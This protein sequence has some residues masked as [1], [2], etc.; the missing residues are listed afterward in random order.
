MLRKRRGPGILESWRDNRFLFWLW[1]LPGTFWI[2]VFFIVPLSLLWVYSFGEKSGI[3]DIVISWT[4]A[5]YTRV[6][7]PVYLTIMWKSFWISVVSTFICL[8]LAYPIA[9]AICFAPDKWKPVLLLIT[10]LPFWINLLIRTY[11]LLAV[12]RTNGFVNQA[13]GGVWNGV[14]Y[15]AT[16]GSNPYQ[17]LELLY[18]NGAVIAGLVYVY[19]PFMVLPLY[20]TVER[21][22]KSY[23]EA[24]LDLGASQVRTL[25]S[26]TIPLTMPG[27]ISGIILV[28][29][30]CLGAF[31]TPALLGGA[32]AIMI[33][34]VIEDQ[35][36]AANDTPFGAALSFI[37]IYITFGIL[38]LR[39]LLTLRSKGVGV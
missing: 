1:A 6:F 21:L 25:F 11:A 38:A 29:I 5:N 22:D 37:L 39:W 8:V 30:P 28:F 13:I 17:P 26:V 36:K 23:L 9:F 7:E 2:T 12:F 34:N 35:F 20:A 3:T 19:L 27:I 32:N 16:G 15:V 18:N 10:I 14:D 24:S 33:G 4:S 31:L